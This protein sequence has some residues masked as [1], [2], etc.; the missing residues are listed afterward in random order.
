VGHEV[1]ER[2]GMN[3]ISATLVSKNWGAIEDH[4]DVPSKNTIFGD[5]EAG[6]KLCRR[7]FISYTSIGLGFGLLS[8]LCPFSGLLIGLT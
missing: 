1:S 8:V 7:S 2:I 6:Q 3:A 5:L 4:E